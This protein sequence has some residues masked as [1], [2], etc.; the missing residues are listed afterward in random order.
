MK[1]KNLECAT[2]GGF[3]PAFKQWWNRDTGYGVC[4]RCYSE[5]VQKYGEEVSIDYF[6]QSGVHH[7]IEQV[8][9]MIDTIKNKKTLPSIEQIFLQMY[10]AIHLGADKQICDPTIDEPIKMFVLALKHSASSL[11]EGKKIHSIAMMCRKAAYLIDVLYDVLE[12]LDI[13]S[14]IDMVIETPVF[15]RNDL[16]RAIAKLGDDNV[17]D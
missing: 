16:L 11:D 6:G 12:N 2:C 4:A 17:D 3:A 9:T 15:L 8:C 1:I 14:K 5:S 7:S 13:N 10:T